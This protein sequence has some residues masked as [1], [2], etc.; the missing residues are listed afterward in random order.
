VSFKPLFRFAAEHE[1]TVLRTWSLALAAVAVWLLS[2]YAQTPPGARGADAPATEFSAMRARD[3]LARLQGPARP[4]PAGTPENAAVH[5]RLEKELAALG[6]TVRHL[7]GTSC[8]GGARWNAIACAEID[9]IIGE[10]VP[11]RGKA[12]MMMAHMDSVPAGPGAGDDGSGVAVILETIRAWKARGLPSRH[13]IIAL[14]TDGEEYGM[15]GAEAFARDPYWSRRVGVVIN[16]EARG[17]TGR[18]LLFQTSPGNGKLIDLYARHAPR[19]ASSSLFPEVYRIAPNDTDLT[20]F[21]RAGF[22]GYNF[23]FVGGV[24]NYHTPHDTVANLDPRALQGH[25]DNLLALLDALAMTPFDGLKGGDA[26]YLD[27]FGVWLPR[28]PSGGMLPLSLLAFGLIAFCGWRARDRAIPVWQRVR[29]GL[30]PLALVLGCAAMGFALHFIASLL[31]GAHNP[32]FAHPWALRWGLAFGLWAMLL[33]AARLGVS[34]AASWLW[35]AG[36]GV[37]TA[38]FLTGISPFFV[39]PALIAAAVMPFA[40]RRP[41]L[42]A[43]PALFA[44]IVWLGLA[45]Q[46]EEFFGLAVHPLF[47]GTAAFALL[48]LAPLLPPLNGRVWRVWAGGSAGVALL[49]AIVAGLLP[50]YS[51]DKPQHVN[52]RYAENDGRAL[53]AAEAPR[54]FPPALRAAAH[55]SDGPQPM[56]LG[57]AYVADAGPARLP[58]PSAEVIRMGRNLVV[59][60]QGSAEA[61]GMTLVIPR[62]AGLNAAVLG[63]WKFKPEPSGAFRISCMSRACRNAMMVLGVTA[64]EPFDITLIEMRRGLPPGADKLVAARAPGVPAQTGD[65]IMLTA[66][67]AVPPR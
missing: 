38:I 55:F 67:I 26:A 54:P 22:T 44:A 4:H 60:L 17:S 5:A 21:L 47:T 6:V 31:S 32:S 13:P 2:V 35:P 52:L 37:V 8:Y 40:P 10:V 1:L 41:W 3:T 46:G 15:L 20:P 42:L 9:D 49:F 50:S 66:K 7:A 45:V 57:S 61:D 16:M 29:M 24:E 19:Y 34:A 39:F 14:F 23:A 30:M 51:A 28:L 36:L 48:A 65:G 56:V 25:G 59:T 64:A 12:I 63:K 53:W 43:V 27:I 33:L 58:K 11:G 62:K 18:S